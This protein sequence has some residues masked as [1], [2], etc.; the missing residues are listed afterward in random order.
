MT[1]NTFYLGTLELSPTYGIYVTDAVTLDPSSDVDSNS[2]WHGTRVVVTDIQPK[3]TKMTLRGHCSTDAALRSL[4]RYHITNYNWNND[5]DDVYLVKDLSRQWKV[6]ALEFH[7]DHDHPGMPYPFTMTL[8]LSELGSEG[9]VLTSK[10]GSSASSPISVT[11]IVNAGDQD[12]LYSSVKIIG[13]Y[14]SGANLTVPKVTH[15]SVGYY[16]DV[17]DV[18]LDTAYFEFF[19]DYTAKHTY[20]DSFNTTDGFTRNKNSSTN[21]TFSTD[22]LVIAAS[23]TLQYRLSLIHPLLQDPVLTLSIS[24][25]VGSPKLEVSSDGAVWWECEKALVSGSLVNY[26]LTKLAGS[27]DFYFRITTAAGESLNVSY[28]KLISWHNYSGQRPIPYLRA[29]SVSE[30][31]DLSFS[32]GTLGYDVRYRDKWSA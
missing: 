2:F 15:Y 5:P 21:V 7:Y 1:T 6:R 12:A 29:D 22:H 30:R 31:L 27:S 19:D 13:T 28:M 3:I 25:L 16:F 20:I 9:Y 11:S 32:A 26:N 18:L 8:T 17:A 14:S 24:S 23:G 4:A 10:T